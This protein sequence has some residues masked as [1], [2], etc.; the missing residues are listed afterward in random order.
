MNS[1]RIVKYRHS[2]HQLPESYSSNKNIA[3]STDLPSMRQ[4]NV[5]MSQEKVTCPQRFFDFDD[6][7]FVIESDFSESENEA[8]IEEFQNEEICEIFQK[9]ILKNKSAT[10]LSMMLSTCEKEENSIY[11]ETQRNGR[12]YT[13]KA[14]PIDNSESDLSFLEYK[15][16]DIKEDQQQQQEVQEGSECSS[17]DRSDDKSLFSIQVRLDQLNLSKCSK[18]AKQVDSFL[19]SISSDS[20]RCQRSNNKK[21]RD[22]KKLAKFRAIDG[23]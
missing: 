1:L 15:I 5:F 12:N 3:I 10:K 13:L 18:E 20:K 6:H 17:L 23:F 16:I 11:F 8:E 9:N 4:V 2:T 21:I 19:S 22:K 14:T 7:S